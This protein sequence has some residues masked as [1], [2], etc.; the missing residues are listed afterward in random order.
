[1]TAAIDFPA[2]T[3]I[4]DAAIMLV[5][6]ATRD[7]S[8]SC[9]FNGVEL[10]A[11]PT[12]AP[13]AIVAEYDRVCLERQ[14]AYRKS[15][16]GIA[17]T[18][19]ANERRRALQDR[20]DALM[21]RLPGLFA[22]DQVTIVD[23]LCAMQG[24]SDHIGVIVRRDTIV[25][26]FAKHGYEPGMDCGADF[27]PDVQ[28]SVFRYLVGQ[29]LDGLTRGPAIHGVIHKFANEWKERFGLRRDIDAVTL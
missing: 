11:T 2:G 26:A 25:A 17:A 16:E 12:S 15:P 7:G 6:A 5:E 29:A 18:E 10:T 21:D 28:A 9:S 23:W 4:D 14:E 22:R 13:A 8:A 24:P 27:K 3:R 1:M 19:R 20:H